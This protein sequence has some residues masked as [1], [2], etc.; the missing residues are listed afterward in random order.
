MP[1]IALLDDY[2]NESLS[3]ADWG[4]L[5]D[6]YEPVVFTDNLVDHDALAERLQDF[7]IICAMRERTP[8]PAAMFERLGNLKL[9]I[10]TGMR[11]ASVDVAAAAARGVVVCGTSG[12][13]WATSEHAWALIHACARNIAHDDRMMRDG[14]WITRVGV[15]LHGKTLGVMGLGRLGGQVATFGKA[16]GMDVIAWSQ[17]LTKERCEEMGVEPV[18][19]DD[20]MRRSDFLTIHLVLS[21]R[22]RGLV[23]AADLGLMKPTSYLINT[24]RGPIIDEAALIKTLKDKKIAGAAVDVYDHEPLPADHEL[25]GLENLLM[26][27]H[28]GY[29]TQESYRV[30]HEHMVENILAWHNGEPIRVIS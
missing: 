21:D 24:S 17:N 16:F 11:N 13:G 26:T 8:F 9:F 7:E 19:K 6:G 5:P 12:S 15:E 30:F 2:T 29:V 20:L 10:T 14:K 1:K 4:K 23:S 3:F 27:P 22:S 25:R 28:T 18:T